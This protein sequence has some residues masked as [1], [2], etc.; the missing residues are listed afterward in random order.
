MQHFTELLRLQHIP[1]CPE[2]QNNPR[3]HHVLKQL[4]QILTELIN[5]M[6]KSPL[7]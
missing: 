4:A 5:L 3:K 7:T 1:R 6:K 2:F